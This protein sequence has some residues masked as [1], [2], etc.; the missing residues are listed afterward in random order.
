MPGLS[1]AIVVFI[2]ESN[3]AFEG[4]HQQH[5]LRRAGVSDVCVMCEDDNRAG[6]KTNNEMKK[7]MA[8]AFK[9][10]VDSK[11]IRLH[12]KFVSLTT[13]S[14]PGEMRQELLEQLLNYSR[15]II[16]SKD[17][18]KAPTELYGGKRGYGYDDL[19]IT[20]QL[21]A[22]MKKRF[23]HSDKYKAWKK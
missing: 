3:L 23:I 9:T 15:I 11:K 13:I 20:V 1:S 14:R 22:L 21:G 10:K 8:L 19:A 4:I 2:P 16:P 12:S 18:H 7:G 17:I 5:A 6:V